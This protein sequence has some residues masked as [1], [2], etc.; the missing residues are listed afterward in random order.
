MFYKL[1]QGAV[2]LFFFLLG[3]KI[4]GKENIPKEGPLLVAGNHVSNWDP[5]IVTAVMTRPLWYMGKAELFENPILRFFM[6]QLQV[7]PVERGKGDLQAIRTAMAHLQENKA[8]GM[9]PEGTRNKNQ[10]LSKF[11]GGLGFGPAKAK[12]RF[13]RLPLLAATV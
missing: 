1:A 9:F 8:L 13:Y 4:E 2:A 7:F 5:V 12:R 3:I 10:D 6:I 11:G